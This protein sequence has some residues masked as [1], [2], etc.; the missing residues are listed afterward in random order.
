[1]HE[2]FTDE[3]RNGGAALGF[4]L[5]S[6]R[7]WASPERS[8]V[9]FLQMSRE[10]QNAGLP[11]GM[12]LSRFGIEPQS[13]V[14]GR[15]E[16]LTELLWAMEEAICCHAVAAVVA[17]I[18]GHPKALDFSASRRLSLRAASA[19]TSVLIL[20]YGRER[21]ASAA[22]LRWHVMPE[23]SRQ[24]PFDARAPDGPRWRVVLEK[25]GLASGAKDFIVDWT[26]NGFELA[27]QYPEK[28]YSRPARSAGPAAPS[29]GA[30]PAALGYRLSQTG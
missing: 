27:G 10:A 14:I 4:A 9:L 25:G 24:R 17:D 8:A 15:T 18:A 12:G 20:R 6:A 7:Q 2:V 30:Q 22:K 13:L 1:L 21:E 3:G 26:E 23:T 16:T 11:Y 29:F 5:G 19:G 28:S